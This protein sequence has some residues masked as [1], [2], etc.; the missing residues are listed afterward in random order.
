[1]SFTS[2]GTKYWVIMENG[3]PKRVT[4]AQYKEIYGYEPTET[5]TTSTGPQEGSLFGGGY[6]STTFSTGSVSTD[7]E[8]VTSNSIKNPNRWTSDQFLSGSS[9]L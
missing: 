8:E 7:L 3:A 9:G 1:M 4:A 5:D 2:G 6:S